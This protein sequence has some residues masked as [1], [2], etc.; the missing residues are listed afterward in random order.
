M[1]ARR[2]LSILF[3]VPYM[4]AAGTERHVLALAQ[5]LYSEHSIGLLAPSGPLLPEFLRLGAAHRAFPRLEGALGTIARG[6]GAF[7]R[8][9]RDLLRQVRPDVIHVHA[10]PELTVLVRTVTRSIPIVLTIHAFHG[11]HAEANY[12]LAGW[13]ARLG[14]VQRVIAVAHSD[15]RLLRTGGLREPRMQVIHN[16]VPDPGS[17][18]IDWRQMLGWPAETPVVGAVGRLETPKGFDILLEAFARLRPDDYP[19]PPRL[20]IVGDGSERDN[21]QRQSQELGLEERV[22]FAGF[23]DDSSRAFGGFDV[24]VIPSRQDGLPLVCLEAM[25]AG[26]PV[27]ASDAG[28]LPEMVEDGVTGRVVPAGD[29]TALAD[30]LEQIVKDPELA[31]RMGEAG[32]A[33]F[34][35]EFH[36]DRMVARTRAVYEEVVLVKG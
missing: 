20:V 16:G 36:V 28:G 13:L 24:T 4:E 17:E 10:G 2:R 15:A 5:G 23:R 29:V 21:L 33:R 25:G 26:C 35:A 8:R 27:I 9:L 19:A 22:H 7:R 34:L 6:V 32:R 14:R 30:A 12:R 18:A 11:R 31:G 1:G 3:V